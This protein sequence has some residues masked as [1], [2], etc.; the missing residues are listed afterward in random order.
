MNSERFV[1]RLHAIR[2]M[3][4]RKISDVDV[5]TVIISGSVI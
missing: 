4:E 1:F 3:F 5:R 2:R